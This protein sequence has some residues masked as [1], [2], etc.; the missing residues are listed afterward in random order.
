LEEK[1]LEV[2]QAPYLPLSGYNNWPE[3]EEG[4]RRPVILGALQERLMI[5]PYLQIK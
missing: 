5:E 2:P 4:E 1:F 3:E